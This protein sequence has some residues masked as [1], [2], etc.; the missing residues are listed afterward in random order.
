MLGTEGLIAELNLLL[1]EF[2]RKSD[3]LH[4]VHFKVRELMNQL[5]AMNEPIPADLIRFERELTEEVEKK[6]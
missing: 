1:N 2:S 5:R 6:R 4:E 3:D